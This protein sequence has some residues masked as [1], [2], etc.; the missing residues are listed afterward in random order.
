MGESGP[1]D[2]VFEALADQR[3]RYVLHCLAEYENPMAMADL[4]TEVAVLE[5]D[6]TSDGVEA[7]EVNCVYVSLYHIHVPK[8]EDTAIVRYDRAKN[9]VTLAEGTEPVNR[10][11]ELLAA[12]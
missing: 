4:A 11:A 1:L 5:N 12:E 2:S 7:E 10:S 8:L 3:R 9:T 6:T